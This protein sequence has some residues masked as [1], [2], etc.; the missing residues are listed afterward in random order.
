MKKLFKDKVVIVTGASSGIG[1]AIAREFA[2]NGSKIVLA[3]M[4][5]HVWLILF[6]LLTIKQIAQSLREAKRETVSCPT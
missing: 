6:G 4:T 5:V 1:K 3:A 2:L